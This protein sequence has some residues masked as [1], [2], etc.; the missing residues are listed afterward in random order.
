MLETLARAPT[1]GR[2]TFLGVASVDLVTF[3]GG[4]DVGAGA[5]YTGFALDFADF[6]LATGVVMVTSL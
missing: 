1:A 3:P 4:M 2:R 5:E 6:V